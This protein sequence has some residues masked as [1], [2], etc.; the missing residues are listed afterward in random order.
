MD[1]LT[2][3]FALRSMQKE[4]QVIVCHNN[5]PLIVFCILMV[6]LYLYERQRYPRHPLYK[7]EGMHNM[8][9]KSY[10]PYQ[11]SSNTSFDPL[12]LSPY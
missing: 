8:I 1:E 6:F 10:N 5:T 3:H 9:N 7:K 11:P 4:S 2:K 12:L